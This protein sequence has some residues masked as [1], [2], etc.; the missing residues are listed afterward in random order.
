M[1]LKGKMIGQTEIKGAGGDVFHEFICK[2]PHHLANATPEKI[3]AF[4]LI[5]GGLGTDGCIIR[6]DYTHDG[7]ARVAKQIMEDIDHEK[8]T[9]TFKMIEG[10]LLD[11]YKTFKIKYHVDNK[12][13]YNLITWTLDYE[14]L[15]D[16]ITHPGT[17]LNFFLH[18]SEDFESHHLKKA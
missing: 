2:T 7:K 10:D 5:D 12:G 8:Q 11:L 16:D 3:Q 18:M 17:L 14:K 6:W 1:G 4:T 15:N 9:I 13:D